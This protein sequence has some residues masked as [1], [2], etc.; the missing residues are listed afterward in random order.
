MSEFLYIGRRMMAKNKIAH[1]FVDLSEAEPEHTGFRSR[2]EDME[3]RSKVFED[4]P[5]TALR[6]L[7]AR[8][9]GAVYEVTQKDESRF[10][11]PVNG[12]PVRVWESESD[13]LYW[14]SL[15]HAANMKWLSN[16]EVKAALESVFNQ[17]L[18]PI[19]EA[20]M[21]SHGTTKAMILARVVHYITRTG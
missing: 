10:Q 1:A 20:Y 9:P 7:M 16:K 21:N 17:N 6:T 3:H 19:R 11:F 5:K 13:R 18:D 2:L 14:E 4:K 15:D 12:K 8:K